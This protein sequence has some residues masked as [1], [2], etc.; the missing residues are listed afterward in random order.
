VD[1]KIH[2]VYTKLGS[3][4]PVSALNV[5]L[6]SFNAFCPSQDK[7]LWRRCLPGAVAFEWDTL[8]KDGKCPC[9]QHNSDDSCKRTNDTNW[10]S[11]DPDKSMVNIQ[12]CDGFFKLPTL[13]DVIKQGKDAAKEKKYNL[14][15]YWNNRGR[16]LLFARIVL[17]DDRK[18]AFFSAST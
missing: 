9:A 18:G 7:D 16:S 8:C 10:I 4:S 11:R 2:N 13:D 15:T 12:F 17:T 14:N 6:T 1:V 3:Y 5:G